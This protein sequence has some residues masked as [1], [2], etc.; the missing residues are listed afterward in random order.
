[1]ELEKTEQHIIKERHETEAD[2]VCVNKTK[3]EDERKINEA[4]KEANLQHKALT[5]QQ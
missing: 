4:N 5:E 3:E 1:M 2:H